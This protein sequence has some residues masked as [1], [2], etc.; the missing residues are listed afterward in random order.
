MFE[1]FL[2]DRRL[3]LNVEKLKILVFNRK[4]NEKKESWKWK[5]R[6]VEEIQTFKYLGFMFNRMGNYKEHIK[7]L[8][9]KGRLAVRKI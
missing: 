1:K 6:K 2:K 8:V 5:G 3:E 9:N 7:E 4:S